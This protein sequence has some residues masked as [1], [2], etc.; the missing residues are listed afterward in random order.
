MLYA[1]HII[2]MSTHNSN[3]INPLFIAIHLE[4]VVVVVCICI[5]DELNAKG[6]R[7]QFVVEFAYENFIY[8]ANL[9]IH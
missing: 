6:E 8:M 9:F 7:I 3:S 1:T 4:E 5:V 2:I